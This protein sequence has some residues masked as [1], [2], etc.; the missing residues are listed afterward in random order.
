MRSLEEKIED[1]EDSLVQKLSL[2]ILRDL[3][4]YSPEKIAN[5]IHEISERNYYI[6]PTD[7]GVREY[8]INLLNRKLA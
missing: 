2:L 1:L 6:T 5:E 7:D 8:V 3:E 4:K